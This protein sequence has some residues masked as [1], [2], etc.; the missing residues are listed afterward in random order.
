MR[1]EVKSLE[2]R[3]EGLEAIGTLVKRRLDCEL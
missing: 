1:K 3:E 2:G